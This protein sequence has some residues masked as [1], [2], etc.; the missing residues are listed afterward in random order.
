MDSPIV[1]NDRLYAYAQIAAQVYQDTPEFGAVR[2]AARARRY[3]GGEILAIRGTDNYATMLADLKA[4]P[5][6]KTAI[7]QVHAGFYGAIEEIAPQIDTLAQTPQVIIGHSEGASVAT[8]LAGELARIGKPPQLVIAFEPAA[9]CVD[10][11]L[12]SL[13][14]DAGVEVY[15]SKHAIDPVPDVPPWMHYVCPYTSIGA[16]SLAHIDPIWYHL[17][18]NI[19]P[20]Y[21]T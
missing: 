6:R 13:L 3:Q 17:I 21:R 19:I 5:T 11:V 2:S 15:A 4:A 20:L 12:A 8:G 16:F 7:G 18:G 14:R 1:A 9:M 10:D